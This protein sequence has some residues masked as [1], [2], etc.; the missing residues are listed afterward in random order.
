MLIIIS[1]PHFFAGEAQLINQLFDLGMPLLHLRKPGATEEELCSL[2]GAIA[3]RH[4]S[5]LALHQ[6]QHIG[7]VYGIERWHLP[8]RQRNENRKMQ[9]GIVYSTSIH[10]LNEYGALD[11]SFAYA[12]L[13]PVFDSISKRGLKAMDAAEHPWHIPE[14]PIPLIALG[15]INTSNAQEALRLGFDGVAVLGAMWQQP[16]PYKALERL[17][18]LAA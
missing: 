4:R 6:Q 16:D 5:K 8:E 2:I 3:E 14:R 17:L 13:S 12:F 11:A 10:R 18:T 9:A 7:E 1:Q 15:G